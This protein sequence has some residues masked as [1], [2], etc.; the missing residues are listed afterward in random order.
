[1]PEENEVQSTIQEAEIESKKPSKNPIKSILA[2]TGIVL[3]N[4]LALAFFILFFQKLNGKIGSSNNVKPDGVSIMKPASKTINETTHRSNAR[5]IEAELESYR[6]MKKSYPAPG[7][8]S[9]RDMTNII[10][11]EIGGSTVYLVET[12]ECT[13][14]DQLGGGTVIISQ[15]GYSITPY[16]AACNTEMAGDMISSKD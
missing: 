6:A 2:L 13:K 14:K 4:V 16:D 8:Y 5:T 1:M 7:K 12:P 3:A 15:N 9:F 10:G 11:R